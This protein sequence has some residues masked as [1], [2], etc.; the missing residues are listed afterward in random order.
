MVGFV[1]GDTL[2]LDV[3]GDKLGPVEGDALGLVEGEALGPDVR[4]LRLGD[5]DGV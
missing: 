2:G 1:D 4:G 5:T 3:V